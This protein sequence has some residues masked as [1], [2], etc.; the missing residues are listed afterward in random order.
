M[1][2]LCYITTY[3][4]VIMGAAI[5]YASL[6]RKLGDHVL[7]PHDI[8]RCSI[9]KI[10]NEIIYTRENQVEEL[11]IKHLYTIKKL[12]ISVWTTIIAGPILGFGIVMIVFS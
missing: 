2:L 4:L 12:Y 8:T 5:W 11:Y 3:W 9:K 7:L 1:F 10:N 6:K